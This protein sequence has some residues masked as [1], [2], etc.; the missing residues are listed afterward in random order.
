MMEMSTSPT[1]ALQGT[2]SFHANMITT[3]HYLFSTLKL[4][5][6]RTLRMFTFY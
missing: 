6:V 5:Y 4:L 2:P 1:L 3:D